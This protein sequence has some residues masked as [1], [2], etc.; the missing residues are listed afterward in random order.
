MRF[1]LTIIVAIITGAG[2]SPYQRGGEA[3]DLLITE[4][5]PGGE[6]YEYI[7]IYNNTNATVYLGD[8][9][10]RYL[11]MDETMRTWNIKEQTKI[12]AGK[13]IVLWLSRKRAREEFNEHY[14]TDIELLSTLN[15]S[16]KNKGKNTLVLATDT[17]A[18]VSYVNYESGNTHFRQA[19]NKKKLKRHASSHSTPG[20]VK[21]EQ[22]PGQWNEKQPE[23][24]ITLT[25][26]N[27][28][29]E[30]PERTELELEVGV[31]GN[32][33]AKRVEM[34]YKRAQDKDYSRVNF[35]MKTLK[36]FQG[37]IS[38]YN[39]YGAQPNV[40][41]YFELSD[42]YGTMTRYPEKGVKTIKIGN[43]AMYKAVKPG[44]SVQDN[45]I[46]RGVKKIQVHKRWADE[47]IDLKLDNRPLPTQQTLGKPAAFVFEALGIDERKKS[48]VFIGKQ[49]IASLKPTEGEYLPYEISI[50][51]ESLKPGKNRI[52]I[53][54]GTKKEVYRTG[55]VTD[56]KEADRFMVKNIKLL[57]DDGTIVRPKAV[58]GLDAEGDERKIAYRDGREWS[59]GKKGALIQVFEFNIPLAKF[60]T[61][62]AEI[63][64]TSYEDGIHSIQATGESAYEA[65]VVFDNS[66][67]KLNPIAPEK[68]KT[69]KG[70]F[71]IAADPEDK[72]TSIASVKGYLDGKEIDLPYTTSSGKLQNGK[73]TVRFVAT[74]AAGNRAKKT[75]P[76]RIVEETPIISGQISPKN[77]EKDVSLHPTLSVKVQDP[78]NDRLLAKFYAG[79]R[80]TSANGQVKAYSHIADEEPPKS[81]TAE[82]E[83]P[84]KKAEL[85]RAAKVDKKYWV[86]DADSGFP[87]QRYQ[88]KVN[89]PDSAIKEVELEWVGHSLKGR[90]I[91][92]YAWNRLES[93]WEDLV[94]GF[95]EEDFSLRASIRPETY[96]KDGLV[97]V[98]IQDQV[99]DVVNRPFNLVWMSDTQY[100]AETFAHVFPVMT[101]WIRIQNQ[102]GNAEYVIH[103]G[104]LVNVRWA[105]EQWEVA[106]RAMS[107]LDENRIPYGVV[108]GNHDV[109]N[110][111]RDY[112]NYARYFGKKRFHESP[113]YDGT[114]QNQNHYDLMSFGGHDFLFLYLGWGHE[115]GRET[116]KW[117]DE[118]LNHYAERNVVLAVHNYL[119][120]EG[121]WTHNGKQIF[122]KIVRRHDNIK[123]VLA[124]HIPGASRH[125]TEIPV[126]GSKGK[127]RKV[128][129]MLADY[130]SGP[131]GGQGYMRM[132]HFDPAHK[133]L[134]VKTYSPYLDDY[135][136]FEPEKDEFT[137]EGLELNP[138]HKQVATDYLGVNVY[139]NKSLGRDYTSKKNRKV[140]AKLHNLEKDKDYFWYVELSD[141]Y[142]G[143]TRSPLWSFRTK[144]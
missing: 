47:Q 106:D 50:P 107:I 131:E 104:D 101:N 109:G 32:E 17:G 53:H 79:S 118:V 51:L 26:I 34:F 99:M 45:T 92:M 19:G 62:Q 49:L 119:D 39:V 52:A 105:K 98:L 77:E 37:S 6:H 111:V 12:P 135:N 86:T 95:G 46:L 69:Y 9:S 78:T 31:R 70:T 121:K 141:R 72:I 33:Q 66:S 22:V 82:R 28:P 114:K 96:M 90:R 112:R 80:Q 140:Q 54:T 24:S 113:F 130:Q 25:P 16:L 35:T 73:H 117:V 125:T 143:W 120:H 85:K 87:Y 75:I 5:F 3:P 20:K 128:Y 63:D 93:R 133:R 123:L 115:T 134:S 127:V 132:L 15:G 74:D 59:L 84:A 18:V 138:I 102:L 100:Y 144:E 7:E 11:A 8:Y 61:L 42:G 44:L 30:I 38:R 122:N 94:Y 83:E 10:L 36:T 57:L 88:V 124:G 71:T 60:K 67:P 23:E 29:D 14:K 27:L 48:A 64:T 139:S 65:K 116:I 43:P 108:S 58:K 126:K 136:F 89:E 40:E 4:V 41:Y 55:K 103:T 137:I 21:K 97:D 81:L 13:A 2:F 129:E 91:T 142:G 1:L 110:L 68:G 56:T 76:F